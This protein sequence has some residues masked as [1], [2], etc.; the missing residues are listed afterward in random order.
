MTDFLHEITEGRMRGKPTTGRGIKML[1]I[2][3]WQMTGLL[4]SNG[5]P[6]TERDEDREW[7]SLNLLYSRRLR[8]PQGINVTFGSS[9]NF[10][11]GQWIY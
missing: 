11:A 1:Q 7:M 9:E 2:M 4:H 5:Q 3:I 6:R 10:Q 8:M